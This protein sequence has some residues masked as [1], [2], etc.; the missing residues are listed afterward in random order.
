MKMLKLFAPIILAVLAVLCV[1]SAQATVIDGTVYRVSEAVSQDAIPANV[2]ADCSAGCVTFQVNSPLN[3]SA[4]DATISDWLA[5]GG[6]FNIVDNG[7]IL[8]GLM[9]PVLVVFTGV[10][11]VLH[12]QQFD[13][14]HDD[15]L[16]L[17]IGGINVV[18]EPG[19]TPPVL[20]S[21]TYT[22]PSGNFPF[23]LVYGE[24]CGGPAVLQV[25]LPFSNVPEPATLAILGVGLVGLGYMRRRRTI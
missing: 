20:T 15:G 12:G 6:A 17:I 7:G 11:T 4:T 1:G 14:E 2:P 22:G 16:T 19:P 8:G 3:F 21:A 23:Q 24:C 13:V 25:E 18:D 5:S 10:V 9:D